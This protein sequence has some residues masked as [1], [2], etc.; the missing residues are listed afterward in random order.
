VPVVESDTAKAAL[1]DLYKRTDEAGKAHQE[2][3]ASIAAAEK[4]AAKAAKDKKQAAKAR[5]RKRK[6]EE[7]KLARG[8]AIKSSRRTFH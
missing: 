3:L 4:K 6:V 5:Q 8:K 1:Q 2:K 7:F